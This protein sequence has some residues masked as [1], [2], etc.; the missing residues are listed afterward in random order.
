MVAKVETESPLPSIQFQSAISRLTAEILNEIFQ[1][2]AYS[3]TRILTVSAV[4]RDWRKAARQCPRLW[5]NVSLKISFCSLDWT[6]LYGILPVFQ[7]SKKE[8]I[9]LEIQYGFSKTDLHM[10]YN[11]LLILP[12]KPRWRVLRS[13]PSCIQAVFGSDRSFPLTSLEELIIEQRNMSEHRLKSIFFNSAP[14]L[15]RL[16]VLILG[17][18]STQQ[19]VAPWKNLVSLNLDAKGSS[20]EDFLAILTQC[21][22][23]EA[24]VLGFTGRFWPSLN[25]DFDRRIYFPFLRTF[26]L[27]G[28]SINP[29][30]FL[31]WLFLPALKL[32]FIRSN[33]KFHAAPTE[34]LLNERF[35]GDGLVNF[36]H[37]SGCNLRTFELHTRDIRF[38]ELAACLCLMPLLEFLRLSVSNPPGLPPF[39]Q[40]H[41]VHHLGLFSG[42]EVDPTAVDLPLLDTFTIH[43]LYT[44]LPIL[45]FLEIVS[46]T[47]LK[48]LKPRYD[49]TVEGCMTLTYWDGFLEVVS[50]NPH[51]S[52]T[53]VAR[54]ITDLGFEMRVTCV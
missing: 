45:W 42:M 7:L 39:D 47:R 12:Y 33:V 52:A 21:S 26:T 16:V 28:R 24:C 50:G 49:K 23:L 11:Q 30:P 41:P 14:N 6:R 22:R 37:A 8:G 46:Q 3:V 43:G 38:S 27:V 4:C 29:I 5:K 13:G 48:I 40:K 1:Y 34:S 54:R 10:I 44:D 32:L 25:V 18:F 51:L 35:Y 31:S 15:K 2:L 17:R 20:C 19:V 9:N 36:L 53:D